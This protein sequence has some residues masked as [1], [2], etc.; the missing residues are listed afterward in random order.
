MNIGALREAERNL[1][2]SIDLCREIGD[3]FRE[4]IGHQVLGCFLSYRGAWQAAEQELDLSY[5]YNS[6]QNDFQGL[7]IDWS[8]RTLRFLL[9]RGEPSAERLS[10]I[11]H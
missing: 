8:Y 5:H 11:S 1:H 4:A 7:S 9:M 2:R 3:E 10:A 6:L